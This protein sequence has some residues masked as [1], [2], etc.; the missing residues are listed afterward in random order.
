[1]HC[2]ALM[3]PHIL[4]I[5]C[6]LYILS[7]ILQIKQI[8]TEVTFCCTLSMH[9]LSLDVIANYAKGLFK[10]WQYFSLH[11]THMYANLCTY[12]RTY[13]HAW[14]IHRAVGCV[15]TNRLTSLFPFLCPIASAA[16]SELPSPPDTHACSGPRNKQ[17]QQQ[18]QGWGG[19]TY[20]PTK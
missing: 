4:H 6:I 18:Q 10:L 12:V 13:V 16:F 5:M 17:Q 15:Y 3:L 14:T 9:S 2:K 20:V 1:M 19:S 7:L 11:T 8:L